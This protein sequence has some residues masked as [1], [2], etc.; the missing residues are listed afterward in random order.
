MS[1]WISCEIAIC[2]DGQVRSAGR[3]ASTPQELEVLTNSLAP[4]DEV[5]L[6]ATGNALAIA[7]LLEPEAKSVQTT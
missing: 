4:D 3:V 2:E 6:E 7:R 1:I 5:A